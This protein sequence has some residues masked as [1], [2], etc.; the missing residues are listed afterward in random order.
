MI[1]R[2]ARVE[3]SGLRRSKIAAAVSRY[4]QPRR[5]LNEYD[6]ATGYLKFRLLREAVL[7][8]KH[9]LLLLPVGYR[10]QRNLL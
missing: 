7:K 6:L 9:L 10:P 4:Q 3:I 1:D 8:G 2:L 5:S